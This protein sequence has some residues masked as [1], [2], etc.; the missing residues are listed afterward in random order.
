MSITEVMNV[1]PRPPYDTSRQT[2]AALSKIESNT[3]FFHFLYHKQ[4]K[5]ERKGREKEKLEKCLK[6]K[7]PKKYNQ[8]NFE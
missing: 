6:T 1:S 5:D 7:A 2:L 3:V 8:S 4:K